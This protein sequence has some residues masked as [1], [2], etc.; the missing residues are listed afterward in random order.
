MAGARARDKE[1]GI[2]EFDSPGH[3]EVSAWLK[4]ATVG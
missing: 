4:M 2:K 1:R 3:G